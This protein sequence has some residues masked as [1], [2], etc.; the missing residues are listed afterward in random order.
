MR[1][2]HKQLFLGEVEKVKKV[3]E[4]LCVKFGTEKVFEFLNEYEYWVDQHNS[5]NSPLQNVDNLRIFR[6]C[7]SH[8]PELTARIQEESLL[9][10]K[11]RGWQKNKMIEEAFK[12]VGDFERRNHE[13]INH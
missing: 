13:K 12:S 4:S 8:Y 3:I 2:F 6:I 10:E 7:K 9:F 11:G 1:A 5:L